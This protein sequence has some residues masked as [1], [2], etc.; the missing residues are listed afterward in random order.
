MKS[1]KDIRKLG[2]KKQKL[3]VSSMFGHEIFVDSSIDQ[4]EEFIFCIS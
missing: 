3:D 1:D 4:R 2:Y